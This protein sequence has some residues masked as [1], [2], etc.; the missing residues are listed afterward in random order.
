[1]THSAICPICNQPIS[2]SQPV[3]FWPDRQTM[4]HP[5]CRVRWADTSPELDKSANPVYGPMN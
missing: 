1:M 2:L 4:E 5:W 3:Y